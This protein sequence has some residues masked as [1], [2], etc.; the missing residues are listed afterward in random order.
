MNISE[1]KT[2]EGL[3]ADSD[4]FVLRGGKYL[5]GVVNG[6][7]GTEPVGVT[8]KTPGDQ[9]VPVVCLA[10]D[11]GSNKGVTGEDGSAVMDLPP[12]TYKIGIGD[13]AGVTACLVAVP[14]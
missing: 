3:D 10:S 7:P 11:G 14:Y 9:F 8:M 6:T 5:L 4:E 2:F 12:G 1:G 13:N